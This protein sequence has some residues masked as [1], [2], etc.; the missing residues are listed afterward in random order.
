MDLAFDEL[1]KHI[2]YAKDLNRRDRDPLRYTCP[3]CKENLILVKSD[4]YSSY[5]KHRDGNNNKECNMYFKA[6]G[7]NSN[8]Y[9]QESENNRIAELFF[10]PETKNFKIG[11]FFHSEELETLCE[12]NSHIIIQENSKEIINQSFD[13]ISFLENS[14]K[15]FN[16]D[17]PFKNYKV[18]IDNNILNI[19]NINNFK[20][21]IFF[22]VNST[23]NHARYVFSGN[24]YTETEY[25]AI[26]TIRKNLENFLFH[27]PERKNKSVI[28]SNKSKSI[29]YVKIKFKNNNPDLDKI[30]NR[31]GYNLFESEE[32]NILWPPVYENNEI[33]MA[34]S[35]NIYLE[36]SFELKE[37][38]STNSSVEKVKM[39]SNVYRLKLANILLV[40]KKNIDLKILKENSIIN[41]TKYKEI[42]STEARCC[43]LKDNSNKNNL[44]IDG[45]GN[46]V[47]KDFDYY[48]F[49]YNGCN[50]LNN[51]E[52]IILN[53]GMKIAAYEKRFKRIEIFPLPNKKMSMEEKIIDALRYYPK[54]E[55]YE[56]HEFK[57]LD[58]TESVK[59]YL[60]LC[61]KCGLI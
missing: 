37:N 46:L 50:K 20:N 51:E 11:I 40:G 55:I 4:K 15:Y 52:K 41:L 5:F 34:N 13:F 60:E 45:H 14:Y 54:V 61:E 23:N 28:E 36:S 12:N 6:S 10:N 53:N 42:I 32:L 49:S 1:Q 56:A 35:N 48:L 39:D 8:Y 7:I 18:K 59:K 9:L 30:L 29:F 38:K 22:K 25:I 21:F 33:L 47:L 3:Y 27:I 31:N 19:C 26:S 44:E 2:V 43:V 58:L 16:I 17:N 24:L 57:N